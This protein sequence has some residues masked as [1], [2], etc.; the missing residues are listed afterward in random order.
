MKEAAASMP[1]VAHCLT[2]N[3]IGFVVA[4][5][6][7]QFNCPVCNTRNCLDCKISHPGTCAQYRQQIEDDANRRVQRQNEE[8]NINAIQVNGTYL[9]TACNYFASNLLI[10]NTKGRFLKQ[11]CF[12]FSAKL[13]QKGIH[14]MP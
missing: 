11:N 12:K 7:R 5:G 3:C 4:E 13:E 6:V 10:K 2:P 1:N 9:S 14:A 8:L